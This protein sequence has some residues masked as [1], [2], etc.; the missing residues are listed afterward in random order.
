MSA[1]ILKITKDP[2]TL[3]IQKAKVVSGNFGNQ[4]W[5]TVADHAGDEGVLYLPW[6]SKDGAMSG[7][8]QQLIKTGVMGPEDFTP[9]EGKYIDILH[10]HTFTFDRVFKDGNQYINVKL[11]G[12][13]TPPA[14]VRAAVKELDL[15]NA[16]AEQKVVAQRNAAPSIAAPARYVTP[17]VTTDDLNTL[18]DKALGHALN[19]VTQFAENGYEVTTADVLAATATIY[20]GY[21]K[22][23]A[24]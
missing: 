18:Y 8:V 22:G 16:N 19:V 12:G 24:K 1:P 9:E 6:A 13:V 10:G 17:P 15:E 4:L 11:A 2:I 5:C 3:T 21:Q 14:V 23:G 7:V 20:I